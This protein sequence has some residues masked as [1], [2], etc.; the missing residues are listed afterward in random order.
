MTNHVTLFEATV[1]DARYTFSLAVSS[2]LELNSSQI[3][4]NIQYLMKT[5]SF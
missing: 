5:K 3:A 4:V 1:S 2:N